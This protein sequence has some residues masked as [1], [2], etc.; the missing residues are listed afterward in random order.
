MGFA[1]YA[2]ADTLLLSS[3]LCERVDFQWVPRVGIPLA[4]G[5]SLKAFFFH[6]KNEKNFI[7]A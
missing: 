5:H 3:L 2:G 6:I 4:R 7:S 1:L